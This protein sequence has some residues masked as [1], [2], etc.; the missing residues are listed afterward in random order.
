MNHEENN[1]KKSK[2]LTGVDLYNIV[3]NLTSLLLIASSGSI[4]IV[5][6]VNKSDSRVLTHMKEL[7][8]LLKQF[9]LASL[10]VP[11]LDELVDEFT[12]KYIYGRYRGDWSP[13]LSM[14]ES[15][16][17]KVVITSI[18][19]VLMHELK[20]R[21]ILELK[22]QGVLNYSEIFSKGIDIVFSTISPDE[23]PS[24][25]KHDIHEAFRALAFNIPTASVM[26]SLRAVEAALRELYRVLKGEKEREY[27]LL[28]KRILEEVEKELHARNI[29]TKQLE[30][31]L[32]YLREI[33]NEAEH[34]DRIF[35]KR[36]AEHIFLHSVYAI[37]EI[38]KLIEK[39]E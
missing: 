13:Y 20:E 17:L 21:I 2:A 27:R 30:G 35:S 23:V 22:F 9:E 26:I 18:N 31:Y 16:K 14:E 33:R 5:D 25:I 34:P 4:K 37:E 29:N 11:Q 36:E 10:Q 19:A 15:E 3:R 24:I 32:D 1:T 8:E 28:W 39:L 6:D 7:G 38:Y 12:K